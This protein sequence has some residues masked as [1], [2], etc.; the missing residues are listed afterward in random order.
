MCGARRL[1][2]RG[3]TLRCFFIQQV[4]LL[5]GT[6]SKRGRSSCHQVRQIHSTRQTCLENFSYKIL[7]QSCYS[8]L[9]T[10][11]RNVAVSRQSDELLAGRSGVRTRA[12]GRDFCHFRNV[13]T[14]SDVSPPPAPSSTGTDVLHLAPGVRMSEVI[15]L[16]ALYA[17][18]PCRGTPLPLNH[19]GYG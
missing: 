5:A 4:T 10:C 17:F 13:H 1:P 16:L 3:T 9:L 12:E 7:C 15:I 18:M 8:N 2:L 11:I 14:G 19:E 6:G